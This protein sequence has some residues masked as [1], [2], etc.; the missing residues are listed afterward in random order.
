MF[1]CENCCYCNYGNKVVCPFYNANFENVETDKLRSAD[2]EDY[3]SA[4]YLAFCYLYGNR[5]EKN[6]RKAISILKKL[7]R[8]K[9]IPAEYILSICYFD[10]IKVSKNPELAFEICKEAARHG[11]NLAE[12]KLYECYRDGVGT[13]RDLYEAKKWCGSAAGH[14]S[15]ELYTKYA[16][17][18]CSEAYGK[19][20]LKEACRYY[21][22]A[23]EEGINPDSTLAKLKELH[24]NHIEECFSATVNFSS[25]NEALA[26]FC[27]NNNFISLYKQAIH[28]YK[29]ELKSVL[30]KIAETEELEKEAEKPVEPRNNSGPSMYRDIN[31]YKRYVYEMQKN[32]EKRGI[33]LGP[34]PNDIT[35]LKDK[36]SNCYSRFFNEVADIQQKVLYERASQGNASEQ[37]ALG[38][39]FYNE[40]FKLCDKEEAVSWFKLSAEQ[41]NCMAQCRLACCY[42][43]GIGT[44]KNLSE[45]AKWYKLAADQGLMIAQ[46]KIGV[47]YAK[48]LGVE[49]SI[50]SAMD[51]YRLAAKKGS[52]IAQYNLG[53]CYF[54]NNDPLLLG[55]YNYKEAVKWYTLAAD[56]NCA[57]A[58]NNLA[59][60]Y[61]YGYGVDIDYNKAKELYELSAKNGCEKAVVNLK[62]CIAKMED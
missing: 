59:G 38:K 40:D 42:E 7:A 23:Y 54:I 30:E 12:I 20:S 17:L 55:D 1:N 29:Q 53:Y 44:T 4:L 46:E 60:C 31:L 13:E 57:V 48:G 16:E 8:K 14:K 52:A 36:I 50:H 5:M 21:L 3:S 33:K 26:D 25:G 34:S 49:Q 18:C 58:Q 9:Y 41:G 45:A 56:Q 37:Y 22:K 32:L 10:G 15:K 27:I 35:R 43:D 28:Y 39:L 62:T 61:F 6:E 24:Q 19:I 51:Y 2:K 11:C 47:F